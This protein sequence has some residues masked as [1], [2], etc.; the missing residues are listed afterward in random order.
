MKGLLATGL[1]PLLANAWWDEGHALSSTVTRL[2][3][4]NE[5][6]RDVVDAIEGYLSA[7][8]RE[9]PEMEGNL[10]YSSV[11]ADHQKCYYW[12]H[13]RCVGLK[14]LPGIRVFDPWH[15]TSKP[16]FPSNYE[17]NEGH[18]ANHFPLSGVTGSDRL[19]TMILEDITFR[20][21]EDDP[22][23]NEFG[24]T[25]SV[26]FQLRLLSHM[27]T[28]LH[29]PVHALETFAA[30]FLPDNDTDLTGGGD[31]GGS[32]WQVD[33]ECAVFEGME[34]KPTNLHAI[35]DAVITDAAKS[36]P[37]IPVSYL[38]EKAAKWMEDHPPSA[39]DLKLDAM[40]ID[41][42]VNESHDMLGS[43]VF[44][45]FKWFLEDGTTP[46]PEPIV[47]P[48]CPSQS[49]VDEM[50]VVARKRVV[51]GGYRLAEV[52]KEIT[53]F[54]PDFSTGTPAGAASIHVLPSLVVAVML[55]AAAS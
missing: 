53:P 6:K 49:Y 27:Y 25:W 52:L 43:T 26:N 44:S 46:N 39:D 48:Y 3:L 47:Q 40:N 10:H 8:D 24:T 14:R 21:Q 37:H 22:K 23:W 55:Y 17:L 54:L 11:W 38:E 30:P 20:G 9:F 5:G 4:L 41:D 35:W 42:L 31:A 33:D 19:L 7:W 15:W 45:E 2:V 34:N 16:W 1:V 51:L 12:S 36:W 28:D 32:R 29:N 13:Y 18:I 50:V